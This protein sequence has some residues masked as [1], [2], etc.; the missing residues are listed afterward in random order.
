MEIVWTVLFCVGLAAGVLATLFQLPGTFVIA[1]AALVAGACTGFSAAPLWLIAVLVVLSVA[2]EIGDNALS[3]W[4]LRRYEGSTRGM[5]CALLGGF[6]GAI[7]GGSF[8]SC[9]G[10]IGLTLGPVVAIALFVVGPIVGGCAGGYLGAL[11]AELSMER[12]GPEARRAALGALLGR[13]A[14]VL[15][16]MIVSIVMAG[17]TGWLVVPRLLGRVVP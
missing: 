5:W 11:L 10:A 12:S 7:A 16:K 3:A 15:M 13:A 8:S 14:G 9:L 6:V 2:A 4:A 1:L 17:G